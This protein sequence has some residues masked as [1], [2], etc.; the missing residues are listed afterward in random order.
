M[1]STQAG[2][3]DNLVAA[4]RE[5]PVAAALIGAG[6]TLRNAGSA[7][8]DAMSAVANKARDRRDEGLTYARES[9]G[10]LGD[11]LPGKE[12][13]TKAQSSLANAFERQPLVL[14]AIGL[15][16]GAAVAGA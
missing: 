11:P 2:F 16:I 1:S 8:S 7:A 10:K 5:N 14:G 4:V 13:F 9:L 15:A 3:V 6:E 12:A